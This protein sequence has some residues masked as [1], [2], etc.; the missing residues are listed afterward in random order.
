MYC[1]DLVKLGLSVSVELTLSICRVY[2]RFHEENIYA[3]LV[4]YHFSS[5]ILTQRPIP[6]MH[7]SKGTIRTPYSL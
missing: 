2:L 7:N 5:N 6:T 4:M 3:S 1:V